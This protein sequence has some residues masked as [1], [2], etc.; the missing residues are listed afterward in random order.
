M[1]IFISDTSRCFC[2]QNCAR[3]RTIL[4]L[5]HF[6]YFVMDVSLE[7]GGTQSG[8]RKRLRQDGGIFSAGFSLLKDRE[9]QVFLHCPD[10]K[11]LPTLFIQAYAQIYSAPA[12]LFTPDVS[13]NLLKHTQHAWHGLAQALATSRLHA[14]LCCVRSSVNTLEHTLQNHTVCN[15]LLW[16]RLCMLSMVHCNRHLCGFY[17]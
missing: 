16:I 4:R 17:T 7:N 14:S 2:V 6:Y 8:S 15:I 3:H 12:A 9:C 5:L 11:C 1:C 10:T 13:P